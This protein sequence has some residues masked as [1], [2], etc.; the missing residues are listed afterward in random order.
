MFKRIQATSPVSLVGNIVFFFF[1]PDTSSVLVEEETTIDSSMIFFLFIKPLAIEN[2][3]NLD[4]LLYLKTLKIDYYQLH[5]SHNLHLPFGLHMTKRYMISI[6]SYIS[7]QHMLHTYICFI[8]Y[9][10]YMY[11]SNQHLL[12]T[13]GEF[14]SPKYHFLISLVEL[15]YVVSNDLLQSYVIHVKRWF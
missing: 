2:G 15:A 4:H 7:N 14:K 3:Q 11:P 9:S 1:E 6:G 8:M 5:T 12:H 13:Y 10:I